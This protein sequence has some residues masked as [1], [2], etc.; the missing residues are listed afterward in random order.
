MFML[1]IEDSKLKIKELAENY[2]LSLVVLFGSQ[3]TERTHVKSDIDIAVLGTERFDML[4]L[5]V[6]FDKIFLRD[7][8]EVVDLENVS[9]TLMYVIVRDGKLLYEN[10]IGAFLK[11]KLYAIWVWLDT[12]WLRQLRDRKLV[13]WARTA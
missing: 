3:A 6:S 1:N 10:K 8:I 2:N 13:E 4:K 11:W 9:P 7:D 5:M 12:T